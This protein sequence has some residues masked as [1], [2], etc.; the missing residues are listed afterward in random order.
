MIEKTIIYP[1][2][3]F[4]MPFAATFLSRYDLFL[5]ELDCIDPDAVDFIY[6]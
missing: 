6:L 1:M 2:G 4:K 3:D 5:V